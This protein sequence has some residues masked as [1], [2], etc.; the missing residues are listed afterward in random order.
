MNELYFC[1]IPCLKKDWFL[2]YN[3]VC[4]GCFFYAQPYICWGRLGCVFLWQTLS[5]VEKSTSYSE[6]SDVKSTSYDFYSKIDIVVEIVNRHCIDI[7]SILYYNFR[8][9][10]TSV[11]PPPRFR[12]LMFGLVNCK[13]Q[14]SFS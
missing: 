5:I 14:R 4:L 2:K 8:S 1:R 6:K 9:T 12:F 3:L 13:F 10:L 7:V 11:L